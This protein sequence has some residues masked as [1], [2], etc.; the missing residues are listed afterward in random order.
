ME[1]PLGGGYITLES[2]KR[3]SARRQPRTRAAMALL[4]SPTSPQT[5]QAHT[6]RFDE[7]EAPPA[8]ELPE[9]MLTGGMPAQFEAT[10]RDVG[11]LTMRL[12]DKKQ[13]IDELLERMAKMKKRRGRRRRR[14]LGPP[15]PPPRSLV[16]IA[17]PRRRVCSAAAAA[18]VADDPRSEL[19]ASPRMSPDARWRPFRPIPAASVRGRHPRRAAGT[20]GADDDGRLCGAAATG[21]SAATPR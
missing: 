3:A 4:M 20:R 18:L 11:N 17:A 13:E 10:R 16:A 7:D 2:K 15:P 14:A 6:Y 12:A 19:A 9:A 5:L 21:R 1:K 8:W